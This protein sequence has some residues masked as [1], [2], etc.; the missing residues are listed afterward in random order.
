M[1]NDLSCSFTACDIAL[2]LCHS[3]NGRHGL[4]IYCNNARRLRCPG[5]PG[6]N[7]CLS[8]YT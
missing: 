7:V 5:V 4:Q 8:K 2:K 1:R 6:K 3:I